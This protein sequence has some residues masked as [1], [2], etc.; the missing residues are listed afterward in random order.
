MY[1]INFG[2]LIIKL[3]QNCA[4]LGNN[5]FSF[6]TSLFYLLTLQPIGRLQIQHKCKEMTMNDLMMMVIIIINILQY[7]FS[8]RGI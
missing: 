4:N 1:N 2:Q 6:N 7:K 3:S 8:A 5:A